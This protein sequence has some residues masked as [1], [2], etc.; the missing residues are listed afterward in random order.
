DPLKRR[1]LA[2]DELVRLLAALPTPGDRL[3]VRFLAE[4]GLRI[5]ELKAVRWNDLELGKEPVVCVR[6][7]HRILDGEQATK[8]ERGSG[9]VPIT[10][11]LARELKAHRLR[12]GQPDSG[13]LVFTGPNGARLDE[14]NF[15][16]RVLTPA[17]TRAGI[18]PIGFH[19]LRHTHGTIVAAATRDVRAVQ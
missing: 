5:S 18:T 16:R 3:L 2:I 1:H 4:T 17:C 9:T 14:T 6:R 10:S 12:C 7:R 15:R 13:E 11:Q 8:S 19:V